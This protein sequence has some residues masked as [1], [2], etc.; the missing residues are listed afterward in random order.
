MV[1]KIC[2]DKPL[3]CCFK[4]YTTMVHNRINELFNETTGA[5]IVVANTLEH[6]YQNVTIFY[7]NG[8]KH[9]IIKV[10]YTDFH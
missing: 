2:G 4:L 1:R 8:S 9:D 5:D 3:L 7:R 10:Y 6:R